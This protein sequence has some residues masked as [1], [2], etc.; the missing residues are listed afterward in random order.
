MTKTYTVYGLVATSTDRDGNATSYVYDAYNLYP[1]TTTNA[2]LQKAQ[3]YFNL[4]NGKVK[5]ST[6]PNNRLT[7]NIFDGLGRLTEV[8]QSSILHPVDVCHIDDVCLY[9]QYFDTITDSSRR[10]PD[11]VE[12]RRYVR[13]LRWLQSSHSRAQAV[14]DI[15]HLH[16]V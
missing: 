11:G 15:G 2:L 13:L 9:R 10:L 4:A 12:Y 6:D 7:K 16:R 1:A 5:Q 3:S 8:D 14:S